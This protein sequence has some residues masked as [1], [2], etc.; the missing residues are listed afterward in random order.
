MALVVEYQG[1]RYSG[2]QLQAHHPTIQGELE[3]A[4]LKLT[5][6]PTRVRGASRTDAG[7]HARGQVVDFLTSATFTTDT[8][9]RG[10]NSY[11]PPDIKVRASHE[12]GLDFNARKDAASRV[13]R[14]TLL[15]SA[16]P[17][18][19]LRE[20]SHWVRDPLD[21]DVM[22]QAAGA[23]VG[24]HDFSVLAAPLLPGRGGVRTVY[25]WDVWRREES[26]FLEVGADGFLPH[27]VRRTSSVILETGLGRLE[28]GAVKGILEGSTEVPN[29]CPYLP[30]KG[31][32]LMA[33]NYKNFPPE[34]QWQ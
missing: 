2:F 4:L 20:F 15:S 22:V 10:L 28:P 7:A 33:V 29:G 6:E 5:G 21:V 34:E 9:L 16:S 17:S 25:C 32:C 24:T 1:T 26:V 27:Q 30:A 14:Y 3:Q 13:Y 19:L 23:L 8:F 12:V 18:P 31:L 11:L